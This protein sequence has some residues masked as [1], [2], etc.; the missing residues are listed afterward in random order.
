VTVQSVRVQPPI[1]RR[2]CRNIEGIKIPTNDY[3]QRR[4]GWQQYII[5]ISINQSRDLIEYNQFTKG[6]LKGL[7]KGLEFNG[8]MKEENDGIQH[9]VQCVEYISLSTNFQ[10]A[11]PKGEQHS[12]WI[13]VQFPNQYHYHNTLQ[14]MF[15]L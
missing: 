9:N 12:N 5:K 1:K 10:I 7:V 8:R 6:L 11:N 4:S 2:H 14:I 15:N 3:K 13:H